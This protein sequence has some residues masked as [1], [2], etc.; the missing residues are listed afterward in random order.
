VIG[1]SLAVLA[2]TCTLIVTVQPLW[3][4]LAVVAVNSIFVQFYFGPLFL[5]P[6]EVLG[7]RMAGSATGFANLFANIGAFVSALGLGLVKDK[8]G[9]FSA[10]FLALAVLCVIGIGLSVVLARVRRQALASPLASIP[11][12][13]G[14]RLRPVAGKA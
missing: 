2:C 14:S 7:Q 10:G 6:V 9:S 12:R 13:A 8:A 3:L 5:V 11:Q 1:A 4:L